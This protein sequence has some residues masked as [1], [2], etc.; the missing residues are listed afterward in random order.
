[1][2]GSGQCLGILC[3]DV[4]LFSHLMV[5]ACSPTGMGV[6]TIVSAEMLNWVQPFGLLCYL[7]S[8]G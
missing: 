6:C 1:M 8:N 2:Q 4:G 5:N 7:P 3:L